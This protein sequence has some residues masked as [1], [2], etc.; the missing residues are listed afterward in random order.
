MKW[1]Q[2][3]GVLCD[4][5]V[6]QKLKGKFY[7]MTIRPAMLYGAECWPTKR[8]HIQQLSVTEMRMLCWICGHTIGTVE[9][10]WHTRS[11]RNNANW[12]KAYSTPIEMVWACPPETLEAPV[13]RGIIRR[14]IMWRDVEGGQTTVSKLSDYRP[15]WFGPITIN[16]PSH[17]TNRDWSRL[18]AQIGHP[19]WLASRPTWKQCREDIGGNQKGLEGMKYPKEVV[20]GTL[21]R[22][23]WKEVI[24]VPE[25]LLCLFPF[26][27]L[28][29]LFPS[30][31][32]LFLFLG[33]FLLGFNSSS[34]QL[35]CNVFKSDNLLVVLTDRLGRLIAISRTT[36]AINRDWSK[37]TWTNHD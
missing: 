6:P 27:A 29:S 19:E 18:I 25:P 35:A 8:R 32:S 2:A 24:H 22:S 36:W 17:L 13:H 5:R 21:D 3:S 4:K 9:K 33:D 10:R 12:R 20:F 16:R 14:A 1:R 34:P 11:A 30:H 15:S 31:F 7:R 28:K 37:P 23:A 26:S